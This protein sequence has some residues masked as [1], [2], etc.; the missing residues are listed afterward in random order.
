MA[1]T[2]LESY[3]TAAPDSYKITGIIHVGA[4][5]AA[6]QNQDSEGEWSLRFPRFKGFRGFA[7]GEKL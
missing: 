6:T 7:V 3:Y 5:D 4:N 2:T 1:S